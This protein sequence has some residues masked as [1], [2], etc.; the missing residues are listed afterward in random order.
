M[1]IKITK[2]IIHDKKLKL[3]LILNPQ[4][5]DIKNITHIKP[6]KKFKIKAK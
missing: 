3:I 1:S 4:N 5:K 6:N 2:N